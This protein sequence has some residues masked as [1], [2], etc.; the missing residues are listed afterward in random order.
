[1]K[2]SVSHIS[3]K[4]SGDY[5]NNIPFSSKDYWHWNHEIYMHQ[6][7][8]IMTFNVKSRYDVK[9]FHNIYPIQF[10]SR[11]LDQ[12][13]SNIFKNLCYLK[14]SKIWWY[15]YFQYRKKIRKN[16]ILLLFE[17]FNNNLIEISRLIQ[18]IKMIYKITFLWLHMKQR[19]INYL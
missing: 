1:M 8:L 18:I 16:P 13:K 4:F 2:S 19:S 17:N 9:N 6:R 14:K 11:C 12:F 7:K 15:N 3:L 5:I 10:L